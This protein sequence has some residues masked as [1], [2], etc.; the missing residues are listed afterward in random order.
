MQ[1]LEKGN[2][3]RADK[4]AT[5]VEC[6]HEAGKQVAGHQVGDADTRGC[7]QEG[8]VKVWVAGGGGSGGGDRPHRFRRYSE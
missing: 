4:T 5:K 7:V 3:R 2:W 6:R 1:N 8:T